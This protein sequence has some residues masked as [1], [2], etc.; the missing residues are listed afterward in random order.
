MK[1][2][3]P[4]LTAYA[5]GEVEE[6]IELDEGARRVVEETAIVAGILSDHFARPRRRN[7]VRVYAMA[8][9]L[10][11]AVGV[12]ALVLS[13]RPAGHPAVAVAPIER[14][15]VQAE[16]NETAILRLVPALAEAPARSSLT[17]ADFRGIHSVDVEQL[18]AAVIEDASRVGSFTSLRLT[19]ES[20]VVQ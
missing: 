16:K 18:V 14:P 11:V 13:H 6:E 15:I 8:A 20:D 7:R 1:Y 9:A 4:K 3:D 2:D 17:S 12:V 5:L 19:P 10:M